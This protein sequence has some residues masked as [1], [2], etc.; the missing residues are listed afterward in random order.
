MPP[1][2][3]VTTPLTAATT[4]GTSGDTSIGDTDLQLVTVRQ[5]QEM[6][7]Q[8][9]SNNKVLK[10]RINGIGAAKVK[11][12]SIKQFLGKKLKLKGFLT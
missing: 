5:L 7:N 8:L 1:K 9:Q 2:A 12:P 3:P 4:L 6:V 10:D 11:L